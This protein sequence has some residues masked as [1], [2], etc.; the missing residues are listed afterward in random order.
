MCTGVDTSVM[1]EAFVSVMPECCL[2][3]QCQAV[4]FSFS[5]CG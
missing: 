5:D 4:I 3:V 2:L 1:K